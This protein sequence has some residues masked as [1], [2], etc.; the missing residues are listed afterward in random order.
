MSYND[1]TFRF[2]FP[3]GPCT[4]KQVAEMMNASPLVEAFAGT[5][6]VYGTVKLPADGDERTTFARLVKTLLGWEYMRATEL[7]PAKVW[8]EI[9]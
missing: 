2:R 1:T 5:E 6:H 3:C 7:A 9:S 8:C 4:V